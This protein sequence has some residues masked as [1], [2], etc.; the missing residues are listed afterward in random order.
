MT[1]SARL[2][3][4]NSPAVVIMDRVVPLQDGTIWMRQIEE[5]PGIAAEEVSFPT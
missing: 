1:A 4:L 5:S 2:R 3:L